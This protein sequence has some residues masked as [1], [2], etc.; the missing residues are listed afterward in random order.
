MFAQTKLLMR[1][2]KEKTIY[3]PWKLSLIPYLDL[4][5]ENFKK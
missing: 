4:F 2:W 5:F 1:F 3:I